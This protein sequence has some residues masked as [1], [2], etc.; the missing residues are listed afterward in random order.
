MFG[1]NGSDPGLA[2]IEVVQK[3]KGQETTIK[4]F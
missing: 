1:Y 3:K 2:V 4:N